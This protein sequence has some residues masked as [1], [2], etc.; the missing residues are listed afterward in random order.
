MFK[1]RLLYLFP[2]I[3][4]TAC[5]CLTVVEGRII[6]TET[7]L[8]ISNATIELLDK[9]TTVKSDD[10]GQFKISYVSGFCFDPKIKVTS[11]NHK[12]FEVKIHSSNHSKSF[13]KSETKYIDYDKPFYPN[14]GKTGTFMTGTWINNFSQNFAVKDDS[15]FIYL[16]ENNIKKE[17]QNIQKTLKENY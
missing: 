2:L 4:L 11:E 14:P 10:K 1:K 3:F 5:D 15:L 7:K 13:E 12:P 17:I 16:D 6:S 8:P 9:K